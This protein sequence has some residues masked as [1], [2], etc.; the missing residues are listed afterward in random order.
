[1]GRQP[2][3]PEIG[4]A[5]Q[6]AIARHDAMAGSKPDCLFIDQMQRGRVGQV[7]C[8]RSHQVD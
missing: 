5:R 4:S 2:A 6:R 3:L 8:G 7:A 1:V